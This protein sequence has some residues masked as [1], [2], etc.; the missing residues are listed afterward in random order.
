M[1]PQSSRSFN[2][3]WSDIF[4]HRWERPVQKLMGCKMPLAG[5]PARVR[6]PLPIHQQRGVVGKAMLLVA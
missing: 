2:L 1:I 6:A 3:S 5:L 4:H